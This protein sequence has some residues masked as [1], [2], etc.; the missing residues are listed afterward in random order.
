MFSMLTDQEIFHDLRKLRLLPQSS[1]HHPQ[2]YTRSNQTMMLCRV[3]DAYHSDVA[4]L[5]IRFLALQ[6]FH[7]VNFVHS[8]GLTLGNQLRPDR[9]FIQEDGWLRLIVP[10]NE[11]AS[12]YVEEDQTTE[13]KRQSKGSRQKEVSSKYRVIFDHHEDKSSIGRN[14]NKASQDAT[15][16]PYPGYGLVPFAQWQKGQVSNLAYLM[17]VN[18]AAGRYVH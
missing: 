7:A 13:A 6:L 2:V 16:I 18:A 1:S 5:R 4:D 9:I 15:I 3:G 12:Y 11:G 14:E 17:M 8:K 10:I